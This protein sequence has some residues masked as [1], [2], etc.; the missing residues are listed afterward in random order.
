MRQLHRITI[1]THFIRTSEETKRYQ[2]STLTVFVCSTI[3]SRFIEE[4]TFE[5]SEISSTLL[6]LI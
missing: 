4:N 6:I 5:M 1:R 2:I 3:G